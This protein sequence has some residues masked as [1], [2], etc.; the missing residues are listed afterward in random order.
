MPAT[1][2]KLGPVYR[3]L[4]MD[5]NFKAEHMHL[6]NPSNEVSLMDGL[7]FMVSDKR[8]KSHSA[9]ARDHDQSKPSKCLTAKA[10]VLSHIPWWTFRKAKAKFLSR[11]LKEAIKNAVE[12]KLAFDNLNETAQ[13][14]MVIL[15]KEE[16]VLAHTNRVEDPAAMDIYEV[17]LERGKSP[18]R[19]QQEL[20][21]LQ[22]QNHPNHPVINPLVNEEL[23]L[24]SQ[25]VSL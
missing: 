17:Q 9:I 6:V 18:T 13:H 25:L 10:D 8:Y 20:R 16:E 11:K 12:S 14:D 5:G 4:V 22:A 1:G 24:G 15:W 2:Y 23:P 7:G 21:L 3:Y 19:K